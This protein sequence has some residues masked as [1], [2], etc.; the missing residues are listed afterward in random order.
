[1]TF[2]NLQLGEENLNCH[3]MQRERAR[4]VGRCALGVQVHKPIVDMIV[5]CEILGN[6]LLRH[7]RLLLKFSLSSVV[8]CSSRCIAVFS[9]G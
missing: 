8:H 6:R 7:Y 4:Y 5:A 1:M 2:V 3:L 9:L